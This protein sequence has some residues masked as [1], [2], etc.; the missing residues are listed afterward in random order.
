M[1]VGIVSGQ[2]SATGSAEYFGYNTIGGTTWGEN[3]NQWIR[4]KTYVTGFTCPGSGTK[5]VVEL[6]AYVGW[7]QTTPT[8][9]LAIYDTSHNLV[10][11]GTSAVSMVAASWQGHM[12]ASTITPNPCNLT[13]GTQY[14]L[15][16]AVAGGSGDWMQY[17]LSAASGSDTYGT[18]DYATGGFPASLADATD[19]AAVV[20]IRCGVQ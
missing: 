17:Y 5:T 20:S 18:T 9:R 1:N 10:C 3:G 19:A 8:I 15:A 14:D 4:N 13:G 12:T 11:Q 6:S 2:V 16:Y 7:L